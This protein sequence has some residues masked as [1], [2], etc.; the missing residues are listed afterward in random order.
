MTPLRKFIYQTTGAFFKTALVTVPVVF[1]ITVTLGNP[2]VIEKAL[3]QSGVYGQVVDTVLDNSKDQVKDTNTQNLLD[4]QQV[5]AAAKKAFSPELLET[6]TTS[7]IDGVF[8]W[9]QGKTAEP[10][11]SI[12]ISSAKASFVRSLTDYAQAKAS[13]LPVCTLQQL[14]T[15]DL[16]SDVLSL[17]CRP[18]GVD[19]AQVASQFNQQ[20]LSNTDF[21]DKSVIT[22][23]TIAEQNNG[24]S[25]ADS[26]QNL[27]AAYQSIQTGKW[28]LLVLTLVLGVL[29]VV[30]RRDKRAGLRHVSWALL[31]SGIFLAI[32]LIVYWYVF[33][34]AA[35][36]R[37]G[38]E[39]VQAAWIDG[40][41]V[42]LGEASRVIGTF[43]AVYTVIGA[44][45][46]LLLKLRPNLLP[47]YSN[48]STVVPATNAQLDP[49]VDDQA[50]K[51][52]N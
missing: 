47:G 20:V 22:N 1:A 51:P 35:R 6:S 37:V 23:Q 2:A 38:L 21:L 27:P 43:A 33:N 17:P 9:L 39:A 48:T 13:A 10:V 41:R 26:A 18:P 14:Q 29:L 11:F 19:P 52:S 25:L 49:I 45:V 12:D 3:K 28:V 46:L 30:A 50:T 24:K 42:I 34:N 4:D 8:A 31:M 44:V 15:I 32:S 5:R 36:G 16:N 7:V 40:S